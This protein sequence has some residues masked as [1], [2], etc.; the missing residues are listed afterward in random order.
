[1]Y[2]NQEMKEPDRNEFV[3]AIIKG[4]NDHIVSKNW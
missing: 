1:M 4:M 2:F 3:K